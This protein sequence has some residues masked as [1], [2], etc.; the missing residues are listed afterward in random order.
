MQSRVEDILMAIINGTSS[1]ELPPP[2]S[3]NEALLLR[4]LDKINEG[5]GG[6]MPVHI[7]TSDEYNHTTGVPTITNPDEGTLYLVPASSATTGNLFDE[8]VYVD[9]AWEKVGSVDVEIPQSDWTQNDSTAADYIKHKPT[10]PAAQVQADWAQTDSAAV[11]YIKNKLEIDDSL[12]IQGAAADAAK[13]GELKSAFEGYVGGVLA[14]NTSDVSISGEY[15]EYN[16]VITSAASWSRSIALPISDSLLKITITTGSK[17]CSVAFFSSNVI[18]QDTFISRLYAR[19]SAITPSNAIETSIPANAEYYVI[20]NN[21]NNSDFACFLTY[22]TPENVQTELVSKIYGDI[23]VYSFTNT[24]LTNVGKYITTTGILDSADSFSTSQMFEVNPLVK[25][26]IIKGCGK[27]SG[28]VVA[29]Y[30]TDSFVSDAYIGGF[31]SPSASVTSGNPVTVNVPEGAKYI[32]VSNRMSGETEPLVVEMNASSVSDAIGNL[33]NQY[34]TI[35]SKT[36]SVIY[37][38]T[39]IVKFIGDSI[40]AGVGGT[41]YAT[42][43][44]IIYGDKKVNENGHCWANSLKAYLESK[45]GLTAYNYGVSGINSRQL[46][47]YIGSI[48]HGDEDLIVCMIGTNDRQDTKGGVIQ[49]IYD[50]MNNLVKIKAYCDNLGIPIVFMSSIPASVADETDASRHYH[51]EDVDMACCRFAGENNMEYISVY[52]LMIEYCK[53]TETTIDSYLSDGL[54]PNDN[55]YNVMFYL[56]ANALGFSTKR[57]DATW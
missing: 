9:S 2:Q 42:T 24:N 27:N 30:K 14:N 22:L 32:A 33:G 35:F 50:Y 57:P 31:T 11:D 26:V 12:S 40:T 10:I 54:H 15:I 41:G 47:D 7:C 4:V 3:R 46:Y 53:Y 34:E 38:N 21:N 55:G 13:V 56:I 28:M 29:F 49:T 23:P 6:S 8:W 1:S 5:G 16:G 44:E 43:G 51:M 52:K 37:D 39:K 19:E 17:Y 36:S 45:F 48:I 20:S 25:T 18:G